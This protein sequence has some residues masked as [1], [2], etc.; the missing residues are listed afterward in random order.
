MNVPR[1]RGEEEEALEFV[2]D[3]RI[4]VKKFKKHGSK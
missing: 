3:P 4:G 1:D 2:L